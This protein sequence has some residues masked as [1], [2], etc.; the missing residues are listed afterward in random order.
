MGPGSVFWFP[1]GFVNKIVLNYLIS[2]CRR[3]SR[4]NPGTKILSALK[5]QL[6]FSLNPILKRSGSYS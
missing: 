4:T 3:D 5:I 6:S 2:V 1:Y